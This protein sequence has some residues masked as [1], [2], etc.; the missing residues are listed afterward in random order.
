MKSLRLSSAAWRS[1]WPF[2]TGIGAAALAL[3][4]LGAARHL[5]AEAA[6]SLR[7]GVQA[8][9]SMA[10]AGALPLEGRAYLRIP[11]DESHLE[12]LRQMFAIG[13]ENG[14]RFGRVEYRVE[15]LDTLQTIVRVADLQVAEDYPKVKAMLA[16]LMRRLPHCFLQEIRIDR[17]D[18]RTAEAQVTLRLAFLYKT[19]SAPAAPTRP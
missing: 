14:I 8:P 11:A 2:I 12:D 9:S 7:R 10:A 6:T 19:P 5:E 3:V 13:A 1:R 16:E 17:K 4:L 18:H 15:T